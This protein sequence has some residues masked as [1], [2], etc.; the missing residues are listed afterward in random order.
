MTSMITN[1]L[2]EKLSALRKSYGYAQADLAVQLH[3]ELSDYLNW[4][5]G[6]RIP[7]VYQLQKLADL[8]HVA[9]QELVD[10]TKEVTLL[11]TDRT[12]DSVQIPFMK[13]VG[14][15]PRSFNDTDGAFDQTILPVDGSSPGTLSDTRRVETPLADTR[16]QVVP[17]RMSTI[18]E[19]EEAE[20]E[21]PP[22]LK[23]KKKGFD[24]RIWIPILVG[25]GIGVLLIVFGLLR[26][27]SREQTVVSLS[28][29]NR[30][31][32]GNGFAL[33]LQGEGDLKTFGD[34]AV[35]LSGTDLV[36]VSAE[37]SFA[38]GLKK[39][40]TVVCAGN[41]GDACKVSDWKS[42]RMIA[43]GTSHSVGLKSDG[44]VVCT[45]STSACNVSGWSDVAA[46][47]AGN[48]ITVARLKDGTLKVAGSVSAASQL[49][50]QKNVADVAIGRNQIAVLNNSGNVTC[51]AIGSEST[52]NTTA[53]AGMRKAAVGDRFA[54]AL[55]GG[56]VTIASTDDEMVKAVEAW[57]NI[58]YIAAHGGTLIAIDE[59]GRLFGTGDN[60]YHIYDA[61]AS[62]D[63]TASAKADQ[64][65]EQV[66]NVKF[67]V[68]AANLGISWDAVKNAD[69]YE[70]EVNTSPVTKIKTQKAST[71]ISA[72]KLTSGTSYTITIK[73]SANDTSKYETSDALQVN[74]TYQASQ[75]K[76]DTPG[77]INGSNEHNSTRITVSWNAVPNA[78]S[79]EVT[80]SS[81]GFN[82]TSTT[83]SL[84]FDAGNMDSATLE[85]SVAALPASGQTRY[86]RSDEG[87]GR[88]TYTKPI[89]KTKLAVPSINT[90]TVAGDNSLVIKWD[91]VSGAKDYDIAVGD[92]RQSGITDTSVT[93][94]ADQ[95]QNNSTY[96]IKLTANPLDTN[97]NEASSVTDSYLYQTVTPTTSTP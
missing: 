41:S 30:L 54:A 95:L 29:T 47:Y 97:A 23:K 17:T 55:S 51:F 78:G 70:V 90:K 91:A 93:I 88:I 33:Y 67:N 52:S 69:Y 15:M 68:T 76:L 72:D 60:S 10:N 2:P 12:A 48:E 58:R 42:I 18:V 74:Y 50:A 34:S 35:Q 39:D 19:E 14:S 66:Q 44:T 85:V 84:S 96:T 27:R 83:N 9:I 13:S 71:S 32:I 37:G 25:V 46:V 1:R 40:G 80:I 7:T 86:A 28:D 77:N 81:I 3:V 65:L 49:Q 31:A 5:N 11:Q 64:K 53:W 16:T 22:R 57:K 26:A 38:L 59:N 79:Y 43:A 24:K 63:P 56:K 21:K 6:N 87:K 36:Q 89:V 92:W 73:A 8:Y 82:S 75:V 45:G 94:P 62:P 4:E 20:E 61:S